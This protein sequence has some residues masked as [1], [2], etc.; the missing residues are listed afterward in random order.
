MAKRHPEI[1]EHLETFTRDRQRPNPSDEGPS[2]PRH[3]PRQF[4]DRFERFDFPFDRED[5]DPEDYTK[6]FY[7]SN[8]EFQQ[9]SPAHT[10]NQSEH[11]QSNQNSPTASETN[12]CNLQ[13]SNKFDLEQE[14]DSTS[15][16]NQRS[17]SAPPSDNIPIIQPQQSENMSQAKSNSETKCT[18]ERI[19]PIHIEGRDEPVLPKHIPPTFS[20]QH[21]TMPQSERFFGKPSEHFTQF[22]PHDR[23]AKLNDN[24]HHG[25]T[26]EDHIK[27]PRFQAQQRG[28]IPIPVQKEV[29]P[30]K[31]EDPKEKRSTSPQPNVTSQSKLLSPIEQIQ[32]IQK[33]VSFLMKQVEEF[34]E[35]CKDKQYLY[36]DEMLT[37]NLI[38]LDNID[39]QGQENIRSARKEAIKC[40]EKAIG[41]L[42]A[43]ASTN[44]VCL[45]EE[46]NMEVDE[47]GMKENEP[48]NTTLENPTELKE[49]EHMETE[50]CSNVSFQKD[51]QQNM[52][53]SPETPSVISTDVKQ[54]V[55]DAKEPM[56]ATT[57]PALPTVEKISEHK[58][59]IKEILE[60]SIE[61]KEGTTKEQEKILNKKE[62]GENVIKQELQCENTE[63]QSNDNTEPTTALVKID[64]QGEKELD[65]KDKTDKKKGKKKIEKKD[66]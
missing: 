27:Q 23:E 10:S 61:E 8:Q 28:E 46:P 33:D 20:Q 59:H 1:A 17:M 41:I 30:T 47:K 2:S 32:A 62:I 37:R 6:K 55:E 5:F 12:R 15:D 54:R 66:K 52:D 65:K 25:F 19:I 40:I 49:T 60:H 63:I 58:D 34:T 48:E 16:R 7:Q 44:S 4:T 22:L 53:V 39:T 42:E 13:E 3:F 36:L 24:R 38:K 64:E 56:E 9:P 43:K 26:H 21:H 50:A 29:P 35:K 18:N 14:Q 11:S 45:E 57:D 51:S 31:R